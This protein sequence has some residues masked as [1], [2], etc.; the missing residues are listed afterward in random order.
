M[1]EPPGQ[2]N[3][4]HKAGV[5]PEILGGGEPGWGGAY[6]EISGESTAPC[7]AGSHGRQDE[8]H[9]EMQE[10]E[11]ERRERIRME[12]MLGMTQEEGIPC[13]LCLM[14]RCV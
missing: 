4:V 13:L 10:D 2:G 6:E 5:P 7:N 11:E 8:E 1:R 12:I 3:S 14:P 9:S